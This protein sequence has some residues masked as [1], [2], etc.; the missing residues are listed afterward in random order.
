MSARRSLNRINLN[1]AVSR[2]ITETGNN[3][4]DKKVTWVVNASRKRAQ[5]F[6]LSLLLPPSLLTVAVLCAYLLVYQ[7]FLVNTQAPRCPPT[8]WRWRTT[9]TR[10]RRP[11]ETLGRNIV[12]PRKSSLVRV[13][14]DGTCMTSEILRMAQKIRTSVPKMSPLPSTKRILYSMKVHHRPATSH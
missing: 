7:R 4:H 1:L 13:N 5:P 2:P 9:P 8:T 3:Y 10:T 11:P 6:S 12:K 14:S